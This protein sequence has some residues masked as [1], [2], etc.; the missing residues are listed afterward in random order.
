MLLERVCTE[1]IRL[2]T[3]D[4][5]V[6]KLPP[7]NPKKLVPIENPLIIGFP[8]SRD[9]PILELWASPSI[10]ECFPLSSPDPDNK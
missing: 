8:S 4:R 10:E 7:L 3:A 5:K 2:N 1:E 6:A 9:S